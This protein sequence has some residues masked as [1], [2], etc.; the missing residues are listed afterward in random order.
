[1]L[2]V[3][4]SPL[5]REGS[6]PDRDFHHSVPADFRDRLV[7]GRTDRSGTRQ[8]R[9]QPVPGPDSGAKRERS[10]LSSGL[11]GGVQSFKP[12]GA[13]GAGGPVRPLIRSRIPIDDPLSDSGSA[14]PGTHTDTPGAK[15]QGLL[16]DDLPLPLPHTRVTSKLIDK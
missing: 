8:S 2:V 4:S 5:R 13:V 12:S 9:R 11:F 15:R 1:M 6:V 14:L 16:S 10:H 7:Q 3:R